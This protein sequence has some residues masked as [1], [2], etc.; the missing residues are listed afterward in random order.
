MAPFPLNVSQ[1]LGTYG[2]YALYLAIGFA[3]GYVLEISGFGNSLKLARQFYFSELTVLKVMFTGIVVAMVLIFGASA[4]GILDI[5][6]IWVNPTYLWPGIVGGLIMGFG[7][8]IGGFCPGTSLVAMA[9]LKVDGIFY[10][11]GVLFGIFLFGETV[12]LYSIFWTSSDLGRLMLPEVLGLSTGWVVVLVV[13]MALFMFWGA[14][15]LES[16]FG[17]S[18]PASLPKIRYAGAGLL[19]AGAVAVLLIGQPTV[20]ERWQ[21]IAAEEE[22]RL[23][24]RQVQLQPG[25]V[26]TIMHDPA[27]KLVMVDVRSETDYNLFHLVDAQHVPLD[28]LERSIQDWRLEPPNT[29][30]LVISNDEADATAAYKHMVA[31]S[32]PNVYILEGGINRWLAVFAP[33]DGGIRPILYGAEDQLRYDF[34]A[35]FGAAYMAADPDP[36]RWEIEYEPRLKLELKRG[37]LGGGCG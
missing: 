2:A 36:H 32:L 28:A 21:A 33:Q 4:L 35:A 12:D 29:V 8:I 1:T 37:P 3:F 14:E 10:V 19:V 16:I 5:N 25:E 34:E 27:I 17:D 26:L 23:A 11:L 9:T 18:D 22:A 31:Q 15:K 6:L 13:L 7:F 24:G 30:F 20:Q